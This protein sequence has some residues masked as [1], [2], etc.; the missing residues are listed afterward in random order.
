MFLSVAGWCRLHQLLARI[1]WTGKKTNHQVL[2]NMNWDDGWNKCIY[3][4]NSS[5]LDIH[6]GLILVVF[7]GYKFRSILS[8]TIPFRSTRWDFQQIIME[9]ITISHEWAPNYWMSSWSLKPFKAYGWILLIFSSILNIG[10]GHPG[11]SQIT[12]KIH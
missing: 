12:H 5:I 2:L 1:E 7:G 3:A 6:R 10:S 4:L 9:K 11:K 8:W